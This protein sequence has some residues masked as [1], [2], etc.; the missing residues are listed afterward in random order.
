MYD[1]AEMIEMRFTKAKKLKLGLVCC[2]NYGHMHP[3][4]QLAKELCERGHE[5]HVITVDNE[6]RDKVEKIYEGMPEA[7]LIFTEG[8]AQSVM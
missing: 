6:I 3:M 1:N 5:V 7:N 8:P 2:G 4:S